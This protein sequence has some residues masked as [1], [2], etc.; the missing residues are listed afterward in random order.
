MKPKVVYMEKQTDKPK[1]G[2]PFPCYSY[3]DNRCVVAAVP[4]S[5]M[6]FDVICC[7]TKLYDVYGASTI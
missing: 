3:D 1:E 7:N 2:Y 5:S 6:K 4:F